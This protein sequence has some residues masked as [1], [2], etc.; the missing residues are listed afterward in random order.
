MES[1][2]VLEV[3]LVLALGDLVV[4]GL[5]LEPHIGEREDDLTPEV[6]GKVG[7]GQVE[8]TAGILELCRRPPIEHLE[9]EELELRPGIEDVAIFRRILHRP[10]EDVAWVALE[11]SAVRF[12]DVA[13]EPGDTL[14]PGP[15]GQ[16]RVSR[17]VGFE[18]HV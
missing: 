4:G 6:L 18:H 14:L 17:E 10:P 16:E 15:P 11:R 5:D 12:A 2:A 1:V 7:W 9:E 3:D 13:D 8:V